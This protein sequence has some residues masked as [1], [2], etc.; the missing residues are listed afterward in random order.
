MKLD[1][2]SLP[3]L[4]MRLHIIKCCGEMLNASQGRGT[5]KVANLVTLDA[6][7]SKG[8]VEVA[9]GGKA[10]LSTKPVLEHR[11]TVVRDVK[12]GLSMKGIQVDFDSS[13]MDSDY[14]EEL[15]DR[16]PTRKHKR[17]SQEQTQAK[18]SSKFKAA[19]RVSRLQQG[20]TN[21]E[22]TDLK[23]AQNK[24]AEHKGRLKSAALMASAAMPKT[25]R[26]IE[27]SDSI[28][29][30]SSKSD[31]RRRSRQS[32]TNRNSFTEEEAEH[33]G[34][35]KSAALMASAAMPQVRRS[36]ET[37]DSILRS[38][39]KSNGRRRSCQSET[40]RKSFTAERFPSL[41][42][43]TKSTGTAST[44]ELPSSLPLRRSSST[45][46]ATPRKRASVTKAGGSN[47]DLRSN[48]RPASAPSSKSLM[49]TSSP[50]KSDSR[51]K[52]QVREDSF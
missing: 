6:E 33:K 1:L 50:L 2:K 8:S 13:D 38:S 23:I 40:T 25:R 12:R 9:R 34:R 48:R 41:L 17:G 49:G 28:S 39:S 52:K 31:G 27:T 46:I 47:P 4:M 7:H 26:S 22:N 42:R 14:D 45:G 30:S 24:E 36:S 11:N 5:S 32:E 19:A 21:R 43:K 29:R 3:L 37:T 51:R 44:D 20:A 16:P 35:L 18:A 15:H 10:T